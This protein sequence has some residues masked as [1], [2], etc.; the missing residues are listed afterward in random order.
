MPPVRFAAAIRFAAVFGVVLAVA[1]CASVALYTPP[2]RPAYRTDVSHAGAVVDAA[3]AAELISGYRRAN[4][5]GPVSVNPVLSAIA[6]RQAAAQAR[7]GHI[8]HDLGLGTLDRRA[9]KA[10]YEYGAIAENVAANYPTLG[11][12]F[13]AWQKSSEHRANM[14]MR[15][16]DHIGIAV[17]QTPGRGFKTYWA[18]ELGRLRRPPPTLATGPR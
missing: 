11:R 16:V 6:R 13:D 4:G 9:E 2:P 1:G 8:G 7:A 18:L 5:L 12:V 15:D 10:G 3:A 17:V 14:L